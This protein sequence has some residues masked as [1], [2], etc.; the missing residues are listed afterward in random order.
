MPNR[1]VLVLVCSW[2]VLACQNKTEKAPPPPPSTPAVAV[3]PRGPASQPAAAAPAAAGEPI[4][5]EI[6]LPEGAAKDAVKDTD[7]LFITAR[8]RMEGGQA[9]SIVAV[10]RHQKP[11]FPFTFTLGA[12]DVMIQGT[13]FVGPLMI[14]VALDEDGDALTP[15]P[16]HDLIAETGAAVNPGQTGLVLTL[17]AVPEVPPQGAPASAPPGSQPAQK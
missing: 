9:G 14:R 4:Q 2:A 11:T 3:P 8:Q 17:A 5:G 13:P 10:Q 7:I 16:K 1:V 6:R 12:K 15:N